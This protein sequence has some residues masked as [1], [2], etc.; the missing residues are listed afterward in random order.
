MATIR[1]GDYMSIGTGY[2]ITAVSYE[3]SD[4]PNF[5]ELLDFSY[6]DTINIYEWK[7]MVPKR[8]GTGYHGD[9]DNLYARFKIHQGKTCSKWFYTKSK[10]QNDQLVIFTKGGKDNIVETANSLEINFN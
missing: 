6:N 10:N 2:N 5:T 3:L 9:L 8:D 7:S 1:I 4:D